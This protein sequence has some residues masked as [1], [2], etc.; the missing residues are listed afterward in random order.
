[1]ENQ[2]WQV[3]TSCLG[4]GKKAQKIRNKTSKSL[5]LNNHEKKEHI[6]AKKLIKCNKCD[7]K[8]IIATN[9]F[10]K[11]DT[12]KFPHVAIIGL[13]I[14]GITLAIS[15]LHR[16]I[17][18]SI[19]ER[20]SSFNMRAQGYGLTL[21][22]AGKLINSLGI[23]FLEE[24]LV[25]SRHVVHDTYGNVVAEWGKRKWMPEGES[26]RAKKTNIHIARQALRLSFLNQLPFDSAIH[27][28]HQ[29]INIISEN[30]GNTLHFSVGGMRKSIH[31]DLIVGADGIRS[32]VRK[33]LFQND[34][35]PLQYLGCMVIL[36]ICTL[37]CLININTDLLDS[38]TVFQTA[39]G[40]ERIYVMPY[41]KDKIMWQFSFPIEESE[42]IKI[43]KSGS[44]KLKEE[45]IKR[46]N[47]HAPIPDIIANTSV[48][49]VTGYPVYDRAL[50]DNEL[51]NCDKAITLIGDAAHPMSPFKGQGANQAIID[52][53]HLGQM[54]YLKCKPSGFRNKSI[55]EL[56][57]NE[58][59]SEMI[60]RTRIKVHDS[61]KAAQFLHSSDVLD[62]SDQPRRKLN[63]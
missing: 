28:N 7:G 22:Q 54:I 6:S 45:A 32:S 43:S 8:G 49:L 10:L 55:R 12:D 24:G 15:C 23:D 27:W 40:N 42:A 29:L 5:I 2:Y 19:Y 13:G 4:I 47:W 51:V 3:C 39:N 63:D 17:P 35:K 34:E 60:T 58:F 61:A 31:A 48:S 46:L 21:Q 26:A 9:F 57:L 52:G 33:N 38:E 30:S 59:E 11:A 25:S 20:D 18:F 56:F 62:T 41:S 50:I 36:G 37:D 14:S 53:L 44:V 16:G 1:M